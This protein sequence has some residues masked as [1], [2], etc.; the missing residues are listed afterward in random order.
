M[1]LY[2]SLYVQQLLVYE[3]TAN[4]SILPVKRFYKLKNV[5]AIASHI[6][7]PL[8]VNASSASSTLA[9]V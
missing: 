2:L 3:F 7:M 1:A 9:A 6:L 5:E 4:H 8:P